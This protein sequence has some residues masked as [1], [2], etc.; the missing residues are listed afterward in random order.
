MKR[1]WGNLVS[2]VWYITKDNMS[3]QNPVAVNYLAAQF[4]Q[5]I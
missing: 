4:E 2:A 3:S 5:Q 1:P